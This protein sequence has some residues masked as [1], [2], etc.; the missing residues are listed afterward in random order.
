LPPQQPHLR[1]FGQDIYVKD[2]DY[3]LNFVEDQGVYT[4]KFRYF[5]MRNI[6][7]LH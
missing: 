5:Y 2:Q 4:I 3:D 7:N 6:K 1:L